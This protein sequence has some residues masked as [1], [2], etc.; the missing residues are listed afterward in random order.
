MIKPLEYLSKDDAMILMNSL[1]EIS[2]IPMAAKSF[3]LI[4]IIFSPECGVIFRNI[5]PTTSLE[6]ANRNLIM[7][8]KEVLDI[9]ETDEPVSVEL[10]DNRKN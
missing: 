1:S 2:K 6:E 9:V 4:E 5:S 10:F 7:L 3:I 8:L